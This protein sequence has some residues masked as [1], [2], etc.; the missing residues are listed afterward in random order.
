MKI[1]GRLLGSLSPDER[2]IDEDL[3]RLNDTKSGLGDQA[4]AYV[5]SGKGEVVLG[6]IA[7][8]ATGTELDLGRP[9]S[10]QRPSPSLKRREILIRPEP[11]DPAVLQRYLEV[12]AAAYAPKAPPPGASHHYGGPTLLGTDK[13]PKPIR[14]FF[15]EVCQGL[16]WVVHYDRTRLTTEVGPALRPALEWV[17]RLGGERAD[18]FDVLYVKDGVYSTGGEVYRRIIGIR[19]AVKSSPVG[20]VAAATRMP[21]AGRT[22][23][24]RDLDRWDLAPWGDFTAFLVTQAGDAA[25]GVREAAAAALL[26]APADAV[27]ALATD[28]LAKGDANQRRAM[29]AVLAQ[30]RTDAALAVLRAHRDTE[31]TGANHRRDRHG[32]VR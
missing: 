12:L 6:S 21:A 17:E 13:V 26:K 5:R 16:Q 8:S 1:L 30:T 28:L 25:K 22:E 20:L 14:V 23:L 15:T 19:P 2:V 10:N 7:A 29:V 18:F 9:L 27:I 4:V 24:I 11:R 3:T 31:K 32:A